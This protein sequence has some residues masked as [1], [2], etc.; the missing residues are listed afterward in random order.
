MA[1][2]L[3]ASACAGGSGDQAGVEDIGAVTTAGPSTTAATRPQI[4]RLGLNG[5]SSSEVVGN[6]TVWYLRSGAGVLAEPSITMR[7]GESGFSIAS[8]CSYLL[9][10]FAEFESY[11]E[12]ADVDTD[13]FIERRPRP[14]TPSCDAFEQR[15]MEVLFQALFH[16]TGYRI[17]SDEVRFFVAER[18]IIFGADPELIEGQTGGS[19]RVVHVGERQPWARERTGVA[20]NQEQLDDLMFA[21]KQGAAADLQLDFE[22]SVALL[23]TDARFSP[24]SSQPVAELVVDEARERIYTV[25]ALDHGCD[26]EDRRTHDTAVILEVPRTILPTSRFVLQLGPHEVLFGFP[27]E[28]RVVPQDLSAS[29]AEIDTND[30]GYAPIDDPAAPACCDTQII[31]GQF[32]EASRTFHQLDFLAANGQWWQ[33]STPAIVANPL[34]E[35]FRTRD[36][37]A[38]LI[39]TYIGA[40]PIHLRVTANEHDEQYWPFES[41][42]WWDDPSFESSLFAPVLTERVELARP[43]DRDW[44]VPTEI[45]ARL[46]RSLDYDV[47][48][49]GSNEQSPE[50]AYPA[51]AAG[52]THVWP[53][54]IFPLHNQLVSQLDG[55]ESEVI[56]LDG[57]IS[58]EGMPQGWLITKQWADE[59][60]ITTMDQINSDPDLYEALD[61]DGDGRGEFFACP[62]DRPCATIQTLQTE[63]A[64]WDNLFPLSD[65]YDELWSEFLARVAK[66][67]PAVAYVW[68]PSKFFHQAGV[69]VDTMWLSV[70]DSSVLDNST[71]LLAPGA[72][73]L[74]QIAS[75]ESKGFTKVDPSTC[76][77]GPDGCQLGWLPTT[78]RAVV[79]ADWARQNGQAAQLL[80]SAQFTPED[81]SLFAAEMVELGEGLTPEE[82]EVRVLA[83][84]DEWIAANNDRLEEWLDSARS[85]R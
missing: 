73:M 48:N 57:S 84:A 68:T 40:E 20:T 75:D 80:R 4:D 44:H 29:G 42:A 9:G 3:F 34:P 37:R 17:D 55:A 33:A 35:W 65:D 50:T 71:P 5:F 24:C 8:D 31:R 63:F 28:R 46:L 82:A 27:G 7:I 41:T 76:L 61:R 51:I 67:Q 11:A 60:G 43:P 53:S 30:I 13:L 25:P 36:E 16:A 66:G 14:R 79:N 12:G 26:A 19:P 32:I 58:G 72:G 22:A 1:L 10:G 6:S 56:H 49:P 85:A 47:S 59:A 69:G 15:A 18:D 38:D 77:V 54:A 21:T 81:L 78:V 39:I 52:H 64:E 23:V 74:G 45:I 83:V 62:E 70:E 2:A